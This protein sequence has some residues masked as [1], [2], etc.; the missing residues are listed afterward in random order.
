[1]N[2]TINLICTPAGVDMLLHGLNQL[3]R[4][5][6]DPLYRE[7]EA[8]YSFQLQRIREAAVK[9]IKDEDES[10]RSNSQDDSQQPDRDDASALSD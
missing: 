9:H 1:M 5:M 3:P 8:Q 7:I 4:H 10:S 6:S 2:Q